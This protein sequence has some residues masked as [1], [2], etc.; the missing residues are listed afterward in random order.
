MYGLKTS[1]CLICMNSEIT[2]SRK[3]LKVRIAQILVCIAKLILSFLIDRNVGLM[4]SYIIHHYSNRL[5]HYCH[6]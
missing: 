1:T 2:L 5:F 3:T 6:S 4:L